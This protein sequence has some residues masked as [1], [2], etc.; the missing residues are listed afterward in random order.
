MN[1]PFTLGDTKY[2]NDATQKEGIHKAVEDAVGIAD[3]IVTIA[4][5]T[6]AS[7]SATLNFVIRVPVGESGLRRRLG[8]TLSSLSSGIKSKTGVEPTST[9]LAKEKPKDCNGTIGGALVIDKCGV[10]AGGNNS[11]ADCSGTPQGLA[12]SDRCGQ[13]DTDPGNDC[14]ADCRGVWGGT[15]YSTT[16]HPCFDRPVPDTLFTAQVATSQISA[17]SAAGITV[18][19]LPTA[20]ILYASMTSAPLT[21]TCSDCAGTPDGLAKTDNCL[22][23]DNNSSNDC[24]ADCAGVWGGRNVKDAC[25]VCSGDNSSCSDCKNMPGGTSVQDECGHCDANVTNNCLRDCSSTWG[26]VNK[27]DSCGVCDANTT[28]DGESCA[29]AATAAA[30]AQ[31]IS[32]APL[33]NGEVTLRLSNG[34]NLTAV[35]AA[36]AAAIGEDVDSSAIVALIFRSADV[37]LVSTTIA[38][39]AAGSQRETFE[40]TFRSQ[41]AS[42]LNVDET[43]I[44]IDGIVAGSVIVKFTVSPNENY[45]SLPAGAIAA[46]LTSANIAGARASAVIEAK[47]PETITFKLI[48][49]NLPAGG[50]PSAV[51]NLN[52]KVSQ[53]QV[54]GL[55]QQDVQYRNRCPPGYYM[56]SNICIRCQAGSEPNAEQDGCIQCVLRVTASRLTWYSDSASTNGRCRLCP[57]GTMPNDARSACLPCA[58]DQYNEGTGASCMVCP[59]NQVGNDR[60]DGCRCADAYYPSSTLH[61]A[62]H[63]AGEDSS[64]PPAQQEDGKFMANVGVG[65]KFGACALCPDECTNCINGHAFLKP[66]FAVSQNHKHE[67]HQR[68]SSI[69]GFVPIFECKFDDACAGQPDAFALARSDSSKNRSTTPELRYVSECG[70][71]YTG[72][73]CAVC[74]AD[75]IRTGDSCINCSSS[76]IS[77]GNIVAFVILGA[78]LLGTLVICAM[79]DPT[80]GLTEAAEDD[81][82]AQMSGLM[83]QMKILIGY[84][85]QLEYRNYLCSLQSSYLN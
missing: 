57:A 39:I 25:D 44:S 83:T 11:C 74:A 20:Q 5:C 32:A 77:F 14:V 82:E 76:S 67:K 80:E 56:E 72:P 81:V 37:T 65:G 70:T 28:N 31:S 61:L 7:T 2:C 58:A 46:A 26:G 59:A 79:K 78:V 49:T 33:S 68:L 64:A 1:V 17:K 85:L 40:S 9:G 75:F 19:C 23:C 36:M 48:A 10:C 41:T 3:A 12:K 8:L 52:A 24:K 84:A 55:V 22:V 60:R 51:L 30:A 6:T 73:L 45:V 43:Q 21:G 27:I 69:Q 16:V 38:G 53:G 50:V 13:C 63:I 71:G 62:C 54:E 29:A 66:G 42:L 34:S 15:H 4:S 47:L 35:V 18:S